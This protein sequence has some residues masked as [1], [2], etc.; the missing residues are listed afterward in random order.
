M[1]RRPEIDV[2][3]WRWRM[4]GAWQW[5]TFVALTVAEA[6]LLVHLPVWGDGPE[7]GLIAAGLLAACLNL[8]VVAVL[9]PFVGMLMRMRRRDLPRSIAAN[10]AG[11]G[12]LVLLA[13]GL[14]AG[15]LTHRDERAGEAHERGITAAAVDDWIRREEPSLTRGLPRMDILQIQPGLYRTCVPASEPDRPLCVFTDVTTAPPLVNR[16]PDRGPNAGYRSRGAF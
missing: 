15:G 1:P 5:P 3:R 8:I 6:F 12:L 4:R 11:T 16:D 7:G 14:L 9:A 10:Y 13:A 2:T